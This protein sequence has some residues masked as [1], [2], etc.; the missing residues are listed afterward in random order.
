MK[1]TRGHNDAHNDY[2]NDIIERL[3]NIK[4]DIK[5]INKRISLSS[6]KTRYRFQFNIGYAAIGIGMAMIFIPDN[7]PAGPLLIESWGEIVV[8]LGLAIIIASGLDSLPKRFNIRLILVG[9]GTL[10][11][12]V[13]LIVLINNNL[14]TIHPIAALLVPVVGVILMVIPFF[15]KILRKLKRTLK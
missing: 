7:K 2:L 1:N 11:T 8:F 9:L 14:I 6:K 3:E 10:I 15:Q 4:K 12:G 5:S 13:I